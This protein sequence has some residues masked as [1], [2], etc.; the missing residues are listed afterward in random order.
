[1]G[2]T[3]S[4]GDAEWA[5][6]DDPAVVRS[7]DES[8]TSPAASSASTVRPESAS[9]SPVLD[10]APRPKEDPQIQMFSGQLLSIGALAAVNG[11]VDVSK[12]IWNVG[13][14]VLVQAPMDLYSRVTRPTLQKRW[15]SL[16]DHRVGTNPG[17][18]SMIS[19]YLSP[20][21]LVRSRRV[22]RSW[23]NSLEGLVRAHDLY[24]VVITSDSAPASAEASLESL[25]FNIKRED[26]KERR[27]AL[28]WRGTY[29]VDPGS[30]VCAF[31]PSGSGLLGTD[32]KK[33]VGFKIIVPSKLPP[34][35]LMIPII[36]D[37]SASDE[38]KPQWKRNTVQR[39]SSSLLSVETPT[40]TEE[41]L[42]SN[43]G[44][45]AS[46]V[47]EYPDLAEMHEPEPVSA[48]GLPRPS[49]SDDHSNTISAA[50]T[51]TASPNERRPS[52]LPPLPNPAP[53]VHTFLLN[54]P[55]YV[56]TPRSR[57]AGAGFVC[58][59]KD[60][61]LRL[62]GAKI[63][64]LCLP[65]GG[66]P[67][68][69][70]KNLRDE[71]VHGARGSAVPFF[72]PSSPVKVSCPMWREEAAMSRSLSDLNGPEAPVGLYST[73]RLRLLLAHIPK[74]PSKQ[75]ARHL[76]PNEPTPA[77]RHVLSCRAEELPLAFYPLFED[78]ASLDAIHE[79][80]RAWRN[81]AKRVDILVAIDANAAKQA[82]QAERERAAAA[83][84]FTAWL[85][86]PL[87]EIGNSMVGPNELE[88]T[89][90][91]PDN[92]AKARLE[93][94][95]GYCKEAS[96]KFLRLPGSTL[97]LQMSGYRYDIGDTIRAYEHIKYLAGIILSETGF[98]GE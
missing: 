22:S 31:K 88:V 79:F 97:Y 1:M 15:A 29:S 77:L 12:I 96:A 6:K 36:G 32:V 40:A 58:V 68:R 48:L 14:D 87:K 54:S 93:K 62:N 56:W 60:F 18:I 76:P 13:N 26:V 52:S 92:P 57:H 65:Y 25:E 27:I 3:L 19:C 17:I 98:D 23:Y 30:A 89:P 41:D 2:N 81:V 44:T 20:E 71:A 83:A 21:D 90:I 42:T 47:S 39:R 43:G 67:L 63:D 66:G 80:L 74:N 51:A 55:E 38:V 69:H 49:E 7:S 5:V 84:S 91:R 46:P 70:I 50:T 8:S 95:R 11:V 24:L 59:A 37:A 75:L 82:E 85:Q 73:L 45:L 35:E 72:P 64:E 61:T 53:H 10:L 4:L 16:G 94:L 78:A 34:P 28:S 9:G 33:I 86:A